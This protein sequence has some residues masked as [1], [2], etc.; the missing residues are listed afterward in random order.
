MST[1]PGIELASVADALA[2]LDHATG[3]IVAGEVAQVLAIAA[4]C[5]LHQVDETVL[6]EGCERWVPGGADGTPKIGE[7]IA[8]EIGALLGVSPGSAMVRIARVLNVRHRH[9]VLWASVLAGDVRFHE[10]ARVADA[11]A[12]ARLDARACGWV[13]RQCA[14][15]LLTQPWARVRNQI[16]GWILMA[17]PAL[18][19]ERATRAAEARRVGIGAIVDGHCDLWG[20]LDAAD[21]IAFDQALT[22]IAQTLPAGDLDA[23]AGGDGGDRVCPGE[24]E[25][26]GDLGLG[27]AG[28]SLDHR[29][30]AA[31]GVL[32]RQALGQAELPRAAEIIVRID[33]TVAGD[34]GR[35]ENLRIAAAAGHAASGRPIHPDHCNQTPRLAPVATVQGWGAVLAGQLRDLLSGCKVTVRPVVDARTLPVASSYQIPDAMRLAVTERWPVDAFPYGM[36]ASTMCDLDH[37]EPYGAGGRTEVGNL[38]PLKRFGHRVRTHGGWRLD[39]PAPGVLTWTSPHGYTYATTP[40]GTIRIGR[41]SPREY[42]WWQQEPPDWIDPGTATPE[43]IGSSSARAPSSRMMLRASDR[44]DDPGPQQPLLALAP[45]ATV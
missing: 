33:A 39:Q 24:T 31:V 43:S 4:V 11:C 23:R 12:Q 37:S 18:A 34:V 26:R 35:D 41:P 7:F 9:P 29:R 13:D 38:A 21:A 27:G 2:A 6:V 32:A 44:Q 14:V 10:A 17:D 16:D 36:S 19:A 30:A 25:G 28:R 45:L 3:M 8:A 42:R 5:D 1:T 40:S 15:A 20:R 22:V